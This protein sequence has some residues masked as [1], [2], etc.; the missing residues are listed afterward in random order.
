MRRP[1]VLAAA[2]AGL[3]I[4]TGCGSDTSV[5][6]S[7]DA[8]GSESASSADSS[9]SPVASAAASASPS[10]SPSPTEVSAAPIVKVD[11]LKVDCGAILSAADVKRIFNVDIPNDRVKRT[12]DVTGNKVGQTGQIR[13]LYGLSADQKTGAFSMLLTQYAD[14]AAAQTQAG[15]T[16]Q[17]LSDNGAQN[18]STTVSGYPATVSLQDG[19]VIVMP[20]DTWTMA[21]ASFPTTPI[22]PATLQTGLPQLGAAALAR[23]LKS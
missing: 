19:G 17:T 23:I 13:C 8:S 9:G 20:Y 16:A 18:V 21:I 5:S 22:D 2:I 4:V 12:I 11:P 10:P 6:G 1:L 15:V 7:V 14:P 3:L